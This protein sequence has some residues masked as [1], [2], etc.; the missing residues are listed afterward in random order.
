MNLR[1]I[2]HV[3]ETAGKTFTVTLTL[4]VEDAQALWSAAADKALQAGMALSD[5]L[6][7]IGPREDPSV[8]DCIAMLTA[9]NA[10]AGCALDDFT[11]QVATSAELI[12]LPR[13]AGRPVLLSVAS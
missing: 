5:V 1:D 4:N 7:T 12:Q 6:D 8:S 2:G 9:P 11:V 10:V 13:D 3:S